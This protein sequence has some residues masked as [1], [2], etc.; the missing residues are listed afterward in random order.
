MDLELV[1][2]DKLERQTNKKELRGI[3]KICPMATNK[4]N[5]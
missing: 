3:N 2:L 1:L 5:M 4:E